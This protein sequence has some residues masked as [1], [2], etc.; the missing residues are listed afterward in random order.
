[1]ALRDAYALA[2]TLTDIQR[3]RLP[4]LPAIQA[5]EAEMRRYG[6]AAIRA[7]LGYTQL[8]I[9]RNR[10]KRFTSRTWFRACNAL[11][12]LK[13]AFEDQWTE[14]MRNQQEAIPLK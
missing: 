14:P 13:H 11:P 9:T 8:S 6:F 10:I 12:P 1:M 5:Y 7:A 2:Q 3:G 4:L